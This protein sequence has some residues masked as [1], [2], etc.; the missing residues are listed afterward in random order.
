[1]VTSGELS[2]SVAAP[3]TSKAAE[4]GFD[5]GEIAGRV[6]FISPNDISLAKF[7]GSGGY[8]EVGALPLLLL[9]L[10]PQCS[11]ALEQAGALQFYSAPR[12]LHS[13]SRS[14][15]RRQLHD[16]SHAFSPLAMGAHCFSTSVSS[17]KDPCAHMS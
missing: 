9:E 5:L 17:C 2:P 11:P 10:A 13:P 16:G 15:C 14:A 1:M 12:F 7:L 8:G 3:P 6:E 4:R